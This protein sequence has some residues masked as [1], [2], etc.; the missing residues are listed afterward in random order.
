VGGRRGTPKHAWAWVSGGWVRTR[1][2]FETTSTWARVMSRNWLAATRS[3]SGV[4]MLK[5]TLAHV[6]AQYRYRRT[7]TPAQAHQSIGRTQ[8]DVYKRTG[9]QLYNTHRH[10]RTP[11]H[12]HGPY[13]AMRTWAT[14]DTVMGTPTLVYTSGLTISSVMTVRSIL[15]GGP[16]QKQRPHMPHKHAQKEGKGDAVT[17]VC[18]PAVAA[19]APVCVCVCVC[20]CIPLHLLHTGNLAHEPAGLYNWLFQKHAWQPAAHLSRAHQAGRSCV[21]LCLHACAR[22][23]EFLSLALSLWRT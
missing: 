17:E 8:A 5:G 13:R 18:P 15:Q 22:A 20:V 14:E 9:M 12:T 3:A 1:V 21:R 16:P 6:S 2:C 4:L 10:T 23:R 7:S 11:T 19:C